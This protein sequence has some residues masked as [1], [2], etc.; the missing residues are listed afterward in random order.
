MRIDDF[1]NLDL[2]EEELLELEQSLDLIGQSIEQEEEILLRIP[3][4]ERR[5][6]FPGW[7][8]RRMYL[9]RSRKNEN[10]PAN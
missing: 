8:W 5:Y 6:A 2:S 4:G 1:Q 3:F 9:S 10:R 7:G